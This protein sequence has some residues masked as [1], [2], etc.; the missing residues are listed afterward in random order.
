MQ[1]TVQECN[2]ST[3]AVVINTHTG[4]DGSV[5]TSRYKQ[6]QHKEAR[7]APRREA[8]SQGS[9]RQ[10]RPWKAKDKEGF[11]SPVKQL[12]RYRVQGL[13]P[14]EELYRC[15]ASHFST[16]RRCRTLNSALLHARGVN[17]DVSSGYTF[18]RV[19]PLSTRTMTM[20]GMTTLTSVAIHVQASRLRRRF[21][22]SWQGIAKMSVLDPWF[23]FAP[24]EVIGE[25]RASSAPVLF[26]SMG[27]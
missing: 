26:S 1:A 7:P 22:H 16:L 20:T 25:L 2:T 12:A 4:Y 21:S 14:H 27:A 23:L 18:C 8:K 17:S 13:Q 6:Q 11:G 24:L 15:R 19:P 5:T 9:H 3:T 10:I